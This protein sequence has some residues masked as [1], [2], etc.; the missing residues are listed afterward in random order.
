MTVYY[1]IPWIVGRK[2]RR[3]KKEDKGRRRRRRR[4]NHK[5]IPV[6]T[7]THQTKLNFYFVFY[8]SPPLLHLSKKAMIP[9][10][11]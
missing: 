7:L 2:R 9:F 8:A 1:S 3:K 11:E 5:Y 4:E 6:L 10:S